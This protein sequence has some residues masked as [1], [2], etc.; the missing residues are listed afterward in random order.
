MK[1]PEQ[2]LSAAAEQ[3]QKTRD[4]QPAVRPLS[5][6]PNQIRPGDSLQRLAA[7]RLRHFANLR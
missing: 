4:P 5:L 7:D 1:N 3:K 6:Q 2:P